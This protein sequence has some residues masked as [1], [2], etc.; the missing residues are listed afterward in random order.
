MEEFSSRFIEQAGKIYLVQS[1]DEA[2]KV[3]N[4]IA[5]ER[6][7]GRVC[8]APFTVKGREFEHLVHSDLPFQKLLSGDALK[9]FENIDVGITLCSAAISQTGSLVEISENDNY[10]MLSSISR[11][12]IA[13]LEASKIVQNLS[14]LAP[15]IRAQ[16]GSDRKPNITLIG[17]PSRTSDIELKSVLGVHGPHEV[18][19]VVITE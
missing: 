13:I 3:T 2:A 1:V 9:E 11:V 6:G 18:H 19:V 7:K 17:G 5:K 15:L 14:D 4:T 10:K 8:C 16:F 12:H